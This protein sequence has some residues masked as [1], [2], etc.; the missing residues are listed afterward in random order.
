[1]DQSLN[2]SLNI[3]MENE[4]P[5]L[6]IMDLSLNS[7]VN[8]ENESS[9]IALDLRKFPPLPRETGGGRTQHDLSEL[10]NRQQ[11]PA[12]RSSA[13]DLQLK[14]RLE[15]EEKFNGEVKKLKSD[16]IIL[17]EQEET[18]RN[19]VNTTMIQT[20]HY[21]NMLQ[22]IMQTINMMREP[23]STELPHSMNIDNGIKAKPSNVT[24]TLSAGK[25][26]GETPS[27]SSVQSGPVRSQ[28]SEGVVVKQELTDQE[29][30]SPNVSNTDHQNV[31]AANED[32]PDVEIGSHGTRVSKAD[33]AKINGMEVATATRAL[34]C[35]IFDRQTL[36]THTLTGK[37][38]NRF[39]KSNRPLKLQLDPFKVAD[40]TYYVKRV[41]NCTESD[42]RHTITMKCAE[43]ERSFKRR[44]LSKTNLD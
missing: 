10:R 39:P 37:A 11:T 9:E 38:S 43:I 44:S 7:S 28:V 18:P 35:L 1:M 4:S 5:E 34:L 6:T 26:L 14:R 24:K 21:I 27:S 33:L 29:N 40:I 23:V 8:I 42:I 3:K 2:N 16:E 19:E 20:L 15:F 13:A 41:F 22:R 17:P 31:K 25:S 30:I 36:A 32:S 12:D